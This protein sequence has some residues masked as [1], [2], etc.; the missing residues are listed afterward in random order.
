VLDV[1][2][3]YVSEVGC[4]VTQRILGTVTEAS[5]G[6]GVGGVLVSNGEGIAPTDARGRYSIHVDSRVHPFV[7]ITVPDGY[8]PQQSFYRSTLDLKEGTP[9]EFRLVNFP[10]KK[11]RAFSLVQI[12]DTHMTFHDEAL[13]YP[14]KEIL[15]QDLER[16][17]DGS[18]PD[19]IV[20]TGDL[21]NHGSLPQLEAY[22]DAIHTAPVPVYNVFGGHDGNE[23][24]SS[25][26]AGSTFVRNFEKILGPTY[27]SFDWGGHHFVVYPR[28]EHFFS[29]EDQRR[30][31][32]WFWRDLDLH[33][34]AR[35][36][37]LLTHTPP[38]SSFLQKL[39]P[40]GV[41]LVLYGHWHSSKVFRHG[42]ILVAATP[43]PSFGG[44]DTIPRGY[45]LVTFRDGGFRMSLRALGNRD[46]V[47][48]PAR[49]T[50]HGAGASL[51]LLWKRHLPFALH[52]TS[53]VG[54][55]SSAVASIMDEDDGDEGGICSIDTM[56]GRLNWRTKTDASIRNSVATGSLHARGGP[57]RNVCAGL[58]VTGR[59][60]L[61]D[62]A[63]GRELWRSD[64]PGYP[65][66][67]TYTSPAMDD[68]MVYAGA[69]SGY[70]AYDLET[71]AQQWYTEIGANDAWSCYASPRLYRDLVIVLIPRRGVI[72]LDRRSGVVAWETKLAVEYHYASPAIAGDL[73]ITGGDREELAVLRAGNGEIVWRGGELSSRYPTGL[74]VTEGKIYAVT[75]E[76]SVQCNDLQ[77][78]KRYWSFQS[79]EDLLDMTPYK[80]VS[81][82]ILATPVIHGKSL[83]ACG[84]DGHVY[85]LD[86]DTGGLKDSLSLESPISCSPCVVGNRICVGTYDGRIFCFRSAHGPSP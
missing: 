7:F 45:R 70:G 11:R 40:L 15:T 48:R 78:G 53:L 29:A 5:S 16:I 58:S 47:A 69:K 31:E 73:V 10:K 59:L 55:G 51:E 8:R 81:R 23:E 82:S 27:Y 32:R 12:T 65:D 26:A 14:K 72:A 39:D 6:R 9:L 28:E 24:R 19:F 35:G 25:G 44:I 66:R 67:W 34:T 37:V 80:R 33:S 74:L 56:T 18:H 13:K 50:S 85:I 57:I 52:R 41:K 60:Y 21:T 63:S 1:E 46:A 54:F 36:I 22:R 4:L 43:P 86:R 64:L 38:A 30:K 75:S 71:G 77:S 62:L 84:C 68:E 79:G 2:S 3:P 17:M 61:L 49:E 20:A 76:G 42:N 83:I